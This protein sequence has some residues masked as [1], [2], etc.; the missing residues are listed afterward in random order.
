ML[1]R[2]IEILLVEDNPGDVWLTRQALV[3][4]T[5]PK[6]ISV[7]NNGEQA[8]DYLRRRGRFANAI[9]PDL[10]LLDLNLPRRDGLEVL[11]E[12]KSDPELRSIT[13]VILTTSDA[14]VDVNAAYD[15]NANCYVVKPVDL[16]EFTIAIRGIEKFWMATATLPTTTPT[17]SDDELA[18]SASSGPSA[19]K[20]GPAL[21]LRAIKRRKLR[22][23]VGYARGV[24]GAGRYRASC[25]P[26]SKT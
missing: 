21:M 4:G 12:V 16:E 10:I 11:R 13:V 1:Q 26:Q 2:P 20:N 19:Q 6:N 22:P 3:Q 18:D 7:V 17:T 5:V 25:H 8:L 14:P 9:R 23:R 15:L 24:R